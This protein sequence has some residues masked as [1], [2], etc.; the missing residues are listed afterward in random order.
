MCGAQWPDRIPAPAVE[1]LGRTTLRDTEIPDL[2]SHIRADARA[3]A[4]ESV[5]A[6]KD[7]VF[8]AHGLG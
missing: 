3:L 8:P 4:A 7:A 5:A 6:V 2:P 1:R